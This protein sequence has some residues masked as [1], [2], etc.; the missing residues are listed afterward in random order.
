VRPV[1]YKKQKNNEKDVPNLDPAKVPELIEVYSVHFST[2]KV[3]DDQEW[4]KYS[5]FAP[6]SIVEYASR[7]FE[8]KWMFKKTDVVDMKMVLVFFSVT[9]LL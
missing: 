7:G 3:L 1:I 8:Q 2:S 5:R 9:I 6:G 4:G